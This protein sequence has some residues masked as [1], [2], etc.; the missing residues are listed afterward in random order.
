MTWCNRAHREFCELRKTR[1]TDGSYWHPRTP[2]SCPHGWVWC[3]GK[4]IFWISF[5]I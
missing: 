5:L 4:T 1:Y 3:R 2:W